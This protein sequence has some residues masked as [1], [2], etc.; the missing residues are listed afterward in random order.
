LDVPSYSL[1]IW[2]SKAVMATFKTSVSFLKSD[3]FVLFQSWLALQLVPQ[4][5]LLYHCSVTVRWV[6]IHWVLHFLSLCS[7]LL[8][9][10]SSICFIVL[11]VFWKDIDHFPFASYRCSYRLCTKQLLLNDLLP[12]KPSLKIDI[13]IQC[14]NEMKFLI[15]WVIFRLAKSVTLNMQESIYIY[16]TKKCIHILRKEKTVLKL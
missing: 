12:M 8:I 10:Y 1:H 11:T 3:D 2:L 16:G 9:C 13:F 7:A 6:V 14:R 15:F 5:R 4:H